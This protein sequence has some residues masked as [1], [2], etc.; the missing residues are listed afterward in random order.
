M[1][2][3]VSSYLLRPDLTMSQPKDLSSN[4][5]TLYPNTCTSE[6]SSWEILHQAHAD[7]DADE[8]IAG[9]CC[10]SRCYTWIL[11]FIPRKEAPREASEERPDPKDR[12]SLQCAGI[13]KPSSPTNKLN[14]NASAQK[15]SLNFHP[16]TRN[17]SSVSLDVPS[18]QLEFSEL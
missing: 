13:E 8:E 17:D 5:I 12:L 1:R 10:W 15:S 9:C 3:Y 4:A 2:Q 16:Y 11:S 18:T 14:Q 7:A 6:Q